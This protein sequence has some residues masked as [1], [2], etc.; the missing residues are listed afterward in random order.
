MKEKQKIYWKGLEEL[1]NDTDF[2]KKSQDEFP[3]FPTAEELT[4]SRRDFLKFMGFSLAAASLAA[5]EA[6]VKKAIPYLNKPEEIDPSIPNYYA[7]TYAQDGEYCSILVKTR[8]G[9]PIKIEGNE[10]SSITKGGTSARVQASVLGLYDLARLKGFKEN[11]KDADMAA[12]DRKIIDALKQAA[13]SGKPAYIVSNTVMSP[14]TKAVIAKFIEKYPFFR[15][16]SYDAVSA[17]GILKANERSFGKYA[18]PAYDFSKA[19]V[20]VS[21][22][23]DFLGTWL[24][25]IEHA[26]QY[27]QTRKLG[28]DKKTMS[29][30]YQFE[31]ILSLTGANAD[32]RSRIRPS[33]EGLVVAALYNGVA[34]AVGAPTVA[35]PAINVPHIDKAVKDLL[36]AKGKSLV[37][38]G[39]ND[40]DV[41]V[42]VNAIN[43][44]LEN[45]GN[46]LDLSR[47][48]FVR[49]GNDEDFLR[50]VED[51]KKGNVSAVIFYNANPV[52][53]HAK[54]AELA[55]A[56]PQIAL[57]VST[58]DREDETASLCRFITPDHHYLEAWNDAEPRA[59]FYSLAQPTI[60]PLFKTRQAQDSFLTWAEEGISFY[61]FLR[62]YWR[63]NMFKG[64]GS[65]EDFWTKVVHD[66]VYEPAKEPVAEK[67]AFA[68][69][70]QEIGSSVAR[71]YIANNKNVELV[72]YQKVGIGSG[73]MANNP[74]LQELPDPITKATWDN[75]VCVSKSYAEQE[76][77]KQGDV[78]KVTANGYSVELPVLIQPGQAPGTIAI[79]LGYGRTK[80]GNCANN[81]GKN[82]YP[83]VGVVEGALVY[84][85]RQVTIE[86]T[87]ATYQIAQT[88]THHTIMARPIVQEATLKEY[89]KD[90]AA[91]RFFPA[92]TIEGE[93]VNVNRTIPENKAEEL[94][95][96]LIT[97]WKGHEKTAYR[98]N[99]W[100]G[101]VIDLNSCI[102]CSA[103]LI[104]CQTENNVP[105]VGK[106]E[107]INRRE[108]HWIR[109]DRY[110]SFD[111]S[112]DTEDKSYAN[113][114]KMED[115]AD[116]PE[117]VFQPMMCQHCNN[118]PCET[119][120]P[121]VATTHSSEGL[122][123]M[124]YNRCIG[125]R[126]CA[127][128][129]PYKV[130]R[131]NWFNYTNDERFQEVNYMSQ[132]DLGRMVLN[133]DVTV[134][135]RGVMEKCSLCVQRI[136]LAKLEAKRE[137]R[138]LRDGEAKTACQQAC[139][140]DAI[141]FGDMN[142][143]ESR[144]YKLL[145][146]KEFDNGDIKITEPRAFQVLEEYNVRPNVTYLTKI[147]NKD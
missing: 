18:L 112:I 15:H 46:T 67:I 137:G 35:A 81:I 130:R 24:S 2:V 10:L 146:L 101:M 53:D 94:N 39:S 99:H 131:F 98:K 48:S 6:P 58:A 68:A 37:V 22:G 114:Q 33:Q 145:N 60:M 108:M 102:G 83:F 23:A 143:P 105:V 116:D 62:G 79:A 127:N 43:Y 88:Q 47:P 78:V 49:Q 139:P 28:G 26:R 82:A 118:A 41:Q 129:C 44:L 69:D 32:Y 93:K 55:K 5:C 25:P 61:E 128:N 14:S 9:R 36:S 16:V 20:I 17:Y 91:G 27:A 30:H 80:A 134:R 141:V 123:Q 113:Y 142:D 21:V 42:L 77:L 3:E 122:N 57:T 121:V 12:V 125:T 71:R 70:V 147:R 65:F 51:A 38:A 95:P 50:F 34:K 92:I 4:T 31:T 59:G 84:A 136:Q 29:R 135:S 66:G 109:I 117:V 104:G 1:T 140:T 63:K 75:Y 73:A 56:L 90:P 133:P 103:C 8:E 132:T 74:W 119:V 76:N 45:Y 86:K 106:D 72:L 124:T 111:E 52:Y 87:G 11:G 85:Q 120:C 97:L 138:K 89:Q 40:P 64:E 126:Y 115:P 7:S 100:W 110:Y 144:I 19:E 96:R 13:Q 54:G 107:I